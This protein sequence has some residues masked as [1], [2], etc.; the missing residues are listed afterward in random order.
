M[1]RPTAPATASDTATSGE[2][3]LWLAECFW[4]GVTKHELAEAADRAAR[5]SEAVCLQLVLVPADE[6]VLALYRAASSEAVAA[7][8]RRAR[9]PAE[10]IVPAVQVRPTGRFAPER[11]P[12]PAAQCPGHSS[13]RMA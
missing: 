12:R 5:E 10:R 6:I 7:A 8:S 9:L 11:A 2:P 4:P 1:S 3:G 13:A